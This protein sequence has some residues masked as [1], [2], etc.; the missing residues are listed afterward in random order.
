MSFRAAL[1]SVLLLGCVVGFV[2]HSALGSRFAR[3]GAARRRFYARVLSRYSQ[4]ILRLLGVRYRLINA[5]AAL[6]PQPLPASLIVC[7][8][9]SYVDVLVIAAL[10]P[11]VFV[12][13]VETR[14]NGLV[15]LICKLAGCLF[16]E[17]RSRAGLEPVIQSLAEVLRD[18]SSISIFP[19]A[20]T[21]D[22]REL[23][24]F[25]PALFEAALRAPVPVLVLGLNYRSIDGQPLSAVN[26]DQLYYYG[27]IQLFDHLRKFLRLR[28]VEAE[29]EILQLIPPGQY[30]D[31]KVLAQSTRSLIASAYAPI[32]PADGIVRP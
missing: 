13:S 17:R 11:C 3:A 6:V 10:F 16:V 12:T 30:T 2:V 7:N 32:P 15:G 28:R 1:K 8:H 26:H 22:G 4:W 18:G 23:L 21:S 19:E 29:L 31:R 24:P 9:L 20:T 25:R 5:A 27:K 14:Q